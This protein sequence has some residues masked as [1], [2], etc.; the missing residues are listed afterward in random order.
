MNAA[1]YPGD[2]DQNIN[3]G[4]AHMW[5]SDRQNMHAQQDRTHAL[6]TRGTV[7]A[8]DAWCASAAWMGTQW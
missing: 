8:G 7:Q 3:Q 1:A 5:M 4:H 6:V 2:N